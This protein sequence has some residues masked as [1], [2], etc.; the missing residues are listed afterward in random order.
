MPSVILQ[1]IVMPHDIM[2]NGKPSIVHSVT[3]PSVIIIIVILQNAITPSVIFQNLVMPHDI[4]LNGNSVIVHI[5]AKPSVI[6][7]NV[8]L[9][10]VTAP[11]IDCSRDRRRWRVSTVET[12][13]TC[14]FRENVPLQSSR[15]FDKEY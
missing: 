7:L 11:E 1:N 4:M 12:V 5:V 15:R 6:I 9:Q 10:N 13:R 14:F 2:L 3:R 8:V